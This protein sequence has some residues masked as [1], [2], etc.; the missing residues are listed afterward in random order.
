MR[1]F[2]EFLG[3]LAKFFSLDEEARSAYL[4]ALL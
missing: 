3:V 4:K 1:I 2:A